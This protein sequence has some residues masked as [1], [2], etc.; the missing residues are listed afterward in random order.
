MML[1][2]VNLLLGQGFPAAFTGQGPVALY[3]SHSFQRTHSEPCRGFLG[4][5]EGS[6]AWADTHTHLIL[7]LQRRVKVTNDSGM[8]H[9]TSKAGFKEWKKCCVVTFLKKFRNII[10]KIFLKSKN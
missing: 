1:S 3:G 6:A 8:A 9:L 2:Q 10:F 7:A 5:Q 4:R